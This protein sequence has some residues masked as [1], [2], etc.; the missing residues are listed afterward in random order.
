LKSSSESGRSIEIKILDCRNEFKTQ[1]VDYFTKSYFEGNTPNPCLVCNPMIKFGAVLKYAE[2]SGATSLATGHYAR[3]RKD[4]AG[5]YHLLKGVDPAKDQSYFLSFLSQNKLSRACFPLGEM[6]KSEVTKFAEKKGLEPIIKQES[7]DICFITGKT[8]GEF[9]SHQSKFEQAPGLIENIHGE[10]IGNHKGL[11]LFT[12]GQR[13]GINCPA[14]EPYYV[15]KID[16]AGNR[17]VVG[18]KKDLLKTECR[19]TGINWIN[20]PSEKTIKALTR[21]RY[22]HMPVES[23]IT[24]VSEDTIHIKFSIPQGAVTPGQGA[25]FYIGDEVIG[26]GWIKS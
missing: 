11:H 8:Y 3:I 25:V 9:L 21:I 17:L 15:I 24:N 6:T 18:F 13:R 7:Q 23:T 14:S 20:K 19:V 5:I 16:V 22:S 12:I 10:V 4:D 26:G 2:E 1:V